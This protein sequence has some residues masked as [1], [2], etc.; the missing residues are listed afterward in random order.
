M[1]RLIY[2]AIGIMLVILLLI[3]TINAIGIEPMEVKIVAKPGMT[4]PFKIKIKSTEKFVETIKFSFAQPLQRLDGGFEFK[5]V[6]PE[7]FP[8]IK[9]L[10][11]NTPSVTIP[12]GGESEVSGTVTIPPKA[13][14]SHMLALLAEQP[15][16]EKTGSLLLS[17]I[18]AIKLAI[19]ID[20]PIPRSTAQISDFEMVKGANGEPCVQFKVKNSSLVEYTTNASLIVRNSKTKQFIERV[21]LKPNVYW[22]NNYDP[23][24]LPDTTVLF[25]G[26]LTET[27]LPGLYDLQLFFRY[28][29]AGQI[30]LT[31]TVEVK[32]GDYNYP[33]EKLR[34]VRTDPS[35]ISV[36]IRP[37]TISMKGI[38]L[39]NRSNKPVRIILKPMD[40]NTDYQYS[41][42][43]NSTVEF[44]NGQE[45]TLEPG[46]MT[47]AILSVMFPKDAHVQ[48]N[49]G[50]IKITTFAIDG[51]PDPLEEFYIN[52]ETLLIGKYT[53]AAEATDLSMAY[54]EGKL[55][56]SAV[57][58]NTGNI[59]ITPQCFVNLKNSNGKSVDS[60]Q[61]VAQ[62]DNSFIL[63]LKLLTLTGNTNEKLA[64][65]NYK[66]ELR[67]MQDNVEIGKSIFD[68]KVK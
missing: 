28:G 58:K 17:V 23:V 62:N 1:K 53:Y 14:G 35:E 3:S 52:L 20:G 64:P 68:L 55:L 25:N 12:P 4:V 54:D 22:K 16:V 30:L 9:W 2:I 45:F 26:I 50:Q 31:K 49:Y 6:D 57:I 13:S 5:P 44:K 65:G 43:K 8:E 34:I 38:K 40:I 37:G 66:A 47:V 15:P 7:T 46:R 36:A 63:P 39:E 27:L 24:V 32:A 48:G 61:L 21:Q 59:K 42:L 29:A 51:T 67:I 33:V 19:N 41:A 11:F 18:Y 56:L 60:L 10:S